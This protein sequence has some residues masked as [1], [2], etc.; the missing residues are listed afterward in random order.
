MKQN[1]P[2]G[3]DSYYYWK[4]INMILAC[5]ILILAILIILGGKDGLLVPGVFFLGTVM[6][7]MSGIMELARNK[8]VVGYICSVFAGI[9][10]VALIVSIIQIW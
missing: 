10:T 6:C 7:S 9:L 4:I 8:R 3:G 1:K 5:V 2:P